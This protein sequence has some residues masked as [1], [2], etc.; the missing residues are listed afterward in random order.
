MRCEVAIDMLVLAVRAQQVE[1]V[2][3]IATEAQQG[4]NVVGKHVA[5]R[6]VHSRDAKR[7]RAF[8]HPRQGGAADDARGIS[9]GDR[10]AHNLAA[11][12]GSAAARRSA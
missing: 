5:R 9:F 1:E 4:V 12:V 3:S 8:P 10:A 6:C 2:R 7:F 11:P